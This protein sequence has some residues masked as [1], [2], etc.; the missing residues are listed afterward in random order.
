MTSS[1]TG[2]SDVSTHRL[3]R[4]RVHVTQNIYDNEAFFEGYNRLPRSVHGLD[5]APE[6]PAVRALLPDMQQLRVLDLGCGFGW[7]CRWAREHGASS[8]LGVDVSDRMLARAVA[9]TD[10]SGISYNKAD[11][12]TFEPPHRSFD[13][14]YSSLALHY[15]QHLERLFAAVY[16]ALVPG[17]AFVFSVEHPIFTA[18][19]RPGW[20]PSAAG[21]NTWP[22]D[23]YLDEGPRSTDWLAKGVI[24]QHRTIATYVNLLVRSGFSL[25]HINEWGPSD[26]QVAAHPEWKDEQQRP[27]FLIVASERP[28]LESGNRHKR[29]LKPA[30]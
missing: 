20:V 29:D 30:P 2:D 27:P 9:E 14:V 28:L 16:A 22:V 15:I 5:G 11:L 6:W 24:K 10:D 7:F 8:V 13:V 23:G 18:P 25:A 4:W 1:P 3:K 21:V 26:E 19:A 12:E 17:G